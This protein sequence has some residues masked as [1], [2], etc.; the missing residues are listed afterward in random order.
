MKVLCVLPSVPLPTNTGGTL[1]TLHLVQALDRAFEVTVLAPERAEHDVIGFRS[2]HRGRVITVEPEPWPIRLAQRCRQTLAGTPLSYQAYEAPVMAQALETLLRDTKYDVVHF[3]HLHTAQ[4]IGIVRRLQPFARVV[5]DEH[6]VEAQLVRR[7]ADLSPWPMRSLLR[8]QAARVREIEQRILSNA[9]C[10]LA[11]SSRDKGLLQ[12][13]GGRQVLVVPNGV[14]VHGLEPSG[15][16]ARTDVVFVGSMDWWPNSDAA[17][18]L[19]SEIWPLMANRL[20]DSRLTLVGRNP[21]ASLRAMASSTIRVTG[22]VESVLPYL[23]G[24]WATAIP[25]RAGSGTR[26]KILEAAAANVPVVA[27]RLAAEGLPMVHEEHVLYAETPREF[28]AALIRLWQDKRLA[29]RLA[30]GAHRLIQDYTWERI[31]GRL[32][33]AYERFSRLTSSQIPGAAARRA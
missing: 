4:L 1:R 11:C 24:A 12:W 8:W 21:P 3:D 25:L 33:E 22:T 23:Q 2:L 16:P 10:V 29:E 7:V 27:T 26:L 31:E 15:G 28:A 30:V 5:V 6:N 18:R 32:V 14:D 20:G 9:D 17:V 13:S 19:A